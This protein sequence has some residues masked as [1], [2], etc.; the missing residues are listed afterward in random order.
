MCAVEL[1]RMNFYS[2]LRLDGDKSNKFLFWNAEARVYQITFP[3]CV[4]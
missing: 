1:T 3:T 4:L 2:F